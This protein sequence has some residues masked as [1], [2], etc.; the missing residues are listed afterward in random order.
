VYVCLCVGVTSHT[1]A[2]AVAAGASTSNEVA[3]MC[4]AGSEC[5]RCRRSVRAIIDGATREPVLDRVE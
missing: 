3:K 2:D 4:G 5:G 1:V